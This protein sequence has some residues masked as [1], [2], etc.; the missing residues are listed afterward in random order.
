MTTLDDPIRRALA[1]VIDCAPPLGATPTDHVTLLSDGPPSRRPMW[2]AVAAASLAIAGLGASV[3]IAHQNTHAPAAA[4][5]AADTAVPTA[6]SVTTDTADAYLANAVLAAGDSV[7]WTTDLRTDLTSSNA[8]T[9]TNGSTFAEVRLTLRD[10]N[11]VLVS[12]RSGDPEAAETADGR[13]GLLEQVGSARILVGTDGPNARAVELFDGTTIVYVRS[14]ASSASPLDTL[15]RVA[16]AVNQS[17]TPDSLTFPGL[18][19][20]ITTVPATTP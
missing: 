8:F 13:E 14:E 16:Q 12:V 11:R 19:N 15:S 1:L 3:M 6:V 10:G 18:P 9:D 7:G 20:A 4:P 17:W 5:T 2:I